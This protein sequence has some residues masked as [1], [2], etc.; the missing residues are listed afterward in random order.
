VSGPLTYSP[1]DGNGSY[2]VNFGDDAELTAPAM[3]LNSTGNFF[4]DG[5]VT[6]AGETNVTQKDIYWVNA[7]HYTTGSLT[8]SAKNATF[9]NY[10]QLIVNGNAHMYDGEFNLMPNSYTEAGTAEMDNFIVNLGGNT[11]MNIKGA[12]DVKAQG[13]GTFQGFKNFGTNNYVLIGGKTTVASHRNTFSVEPGI[14]YSVKEFEIVKGGSVVTEAYLQEI[15]DG[16]YPVLDL[17]GTGAPFGE[18]TVT[19]NATGC[20]AVWSR[21]TTTPKLRVMAEDLSATEASDFDFNDVVMDVEYVSSDQVKIT[22]LA[23]GGTLPLRINEDDNWEV[24]RLFQVGTGTIVNTYNDDYYHGAPCVHGKAPVELTLNGRFSSDEDTFYSQV[25]SIKLE[26]W[27]TSNGVEQ[28]V[29]MTAQRGEP[30]KKV[31]V[32]TTF[33]W[34]TEGQNVNSVFNMTDW[35]K[36][37]ALAPAN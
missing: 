1:A 31:G 3:T 27:K 30:A 28:W 19:P 15:G 9:Y 32:P 7:G 11:G 6:I 14:T 17:R 10:C 25:R 36:G 2:F 22:L 24:H 35:V 33:G 20:G 5:K 8:F 26:V 29:E 18:L 37:A 23:A 13:D 12:V 4:N 34:A 16:D 21:G